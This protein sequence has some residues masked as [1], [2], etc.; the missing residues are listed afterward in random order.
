MCTFQKKYSELLLFTA[1][2]KE[3]DFWLASDTNENN[4]NANDSSEDI[5]QDKEESEEKKLLTFDDPEFEVK[6]EQLSNEK[7]REWENNRQQIYP[8]S[9][10]MTETGVGGCEEEAG[11]LILRA[12]RRTLPSSPR[13]SGLVRIS[14]RILPVPL[15]APLESHSNPPSSALLMPFHRWRHHYRD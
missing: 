9:R 7:Q 12:A 13:R 15:L 6:I 11:S 14:A 4:S 8:F 2:R 1:W 3:E 10:K 5:I